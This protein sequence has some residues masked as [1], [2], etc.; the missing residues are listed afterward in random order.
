MVSDAMWVGVATPAI[1]H[2]GRPPQVGVTRG[3]RAAV[4]KTKPLLVVQSVLAALHSQ[5]GLTGAVPSWHRLVSALSGSG[6]EQS[7]PIT[8][9]PGG[10]IQHHAA[11]SDTR[12][13]TTPAQ[14]RLLRWPSFCGI[15]PTSAD[16]NIFVC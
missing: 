16:I 10:V 13:W 7:P 15:G 6:P 3:A 4:S 11:L 9:E 5:H 12:Y 14:I 2:E 8:V 1:R